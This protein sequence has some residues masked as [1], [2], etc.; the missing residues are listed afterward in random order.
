MSCWK[1]LFPFISSMLSRIT[2]RP[3]RPHPQELQP[4]HLPPHGLCRSTDKACLLPTASR[5]ISIYL[6]SFL[7]PKLCGFKQEITLTWTQMRNN[8]LKSMNQ[9]SPPILPELQAEAKNASGRSHRARM[10]LSSAVWEG[11]P[12][13]P[14]W[15]STVC[16]QN[17]LRK[18]G[19]VFLNRAIQNLENDQTEHLYKQAMD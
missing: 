1:N 6:L 12:Q 18:H 7:K 11:L 8:S 3:R 17:P 19:K 4:D 15:L 13:S 10:G 2:F 16:E 5:L 9:N 14:V